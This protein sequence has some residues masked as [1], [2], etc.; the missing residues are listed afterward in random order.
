MAEKTCS[1][2]YREGFP[3]YSGYI[4]YKMSVFGKTV[5]ATNDTIKQ[6]LTT[7]PP[8]GIY[9]KPGNREDFSQ[10]DRDYYCDGFPR[11]YP[12]EEKKIFT[13][14]SAMAKSW[15]SSD[16]FKI[17]PQH[18]P[19]VKCHVPGIYSSNI[20]G[21]NFP[22]ST[23]ISI[24]GSYNKG[25]DCSQ[26]ERF[27]SNTMAD[28][29]KPITREEDFDKESKDKSSTSLTRSAYDI[30]SNSHQDKVNL[31]RIYKSKIAMVPTVGYSG[32]T[33]IFQHPVSYLNFDKILE[34]EK[35]DEEPVV[36]LG[37]DLPSRYKESLQLIQPDYEL[38][39][40][41]GYK[42][43]RVGVRARNYHAEN[44]QAASLKAR[45]E[46]KFINQL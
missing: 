20:Y 28:Y 26:T 45:N 46:A 42:G 3:G 4:P 1:S 39:Y 18:I 11:D 40:V 41:V 32:H 29:C 19:G 30:V 35:K 12:L 21:K 25:A 43:F 9:L 7:E 33:S 10:Y 31:M 27:T 34:K 15:V 14:R 8:K 17:Y 2:S 23:G 44:F 37:D 24:K 22:K 36:E 13:N 38:P 5:G 16:K 6:L